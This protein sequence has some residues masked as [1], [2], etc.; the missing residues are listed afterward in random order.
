LLGVRTAADLH[1]HPKMGASWEGYIIEQVLA[2]LAPD[3][4]HFWGTHS[5][6]ELDLLLFKSGRRYGIEVKRADAP[7]RTPSMVSAMSDLGLEA[8]AVVYPGARRYNIDRRIVAV[9]ATEVSK[10]SW[11]TFF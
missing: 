1:R 7:R 2:R 8:L 4:A 6:A 11:P 10:A 5:G 3:E 9:P